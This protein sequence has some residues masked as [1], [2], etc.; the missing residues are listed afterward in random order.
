MK[1]NYWPLL[2]ISIFSFTLGMIIWTVMSAI[3]LPVNEDNSFLRTYQ[4]VDANYNSIIISNQV[5]LKKYDFNLN[6]NE[7][8]FGLTTE[9]IRYSQRVLE[10]KSKHKNLLKYGLNDISL[11]VRDKQT[12]EKKSVNI[13]LKVTMSSSNNFD[14]LLENKSFNNKDNEY[15]STFEISDRNNWNITGTFEVDGIT[16]SIFIKTNAI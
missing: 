5:F 1:R 13:I 10:K 15:V 12:N 7:K 14:I 8:D 4:D 2:F 3:K 11:I 6:I 16:G 9:D